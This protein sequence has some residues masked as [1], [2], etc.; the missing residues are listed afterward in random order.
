MRFN[1]IL[2][3]L[4]VFVFKLQGQSF[5]TY[6]TGDTA[7]VV[8]RLAGGVVLMGGGVENDEA[9]RW[10]LR[11]CGGG[12]VL[13]LRAGGGDGYQDYLYKELGISV[14]SV[15]TIVFHS[16]EAAFLPEIESKIKA[17]D[18]L[19]LAG[20]DQSKYLLY[21]KDTPVQTAIQYLISEKNAPVGGTSAGMAVLGQA[22]FAAY[23]NTVGS[24]A[25][26]RNPYAP[27]VSLG[28]DDFIRH[29]DL[30]HII[31]DTHYD[32]RNRKGRHVVFMARLMQDYG[33]QPI[34]IACQTGAAV[35]MDTSGW[36]QVF[37]NFPKSSDFAYF[38]RVNPKHPEGPERCKAGKSLN[39]NCRGQALEVY[40][41]PGTLN[42]SEGI[43]LKDWRR[44]R[45]SNFQKYNWWVQN[46]HLKTRKT[47]N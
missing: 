8:T 1:L 45:G 47:T 17:A 37:G 29:P 42:G 28:Y 36:A 24:R 22:Y 27:E 21:W 3:F 23:L 35:C 6:F 16:R 13:V 9:M 4:C 26:L 40:V 43:Q 34:G 12:D 44:F 33:I 38:I 11:R 10:F 14:N 25:A 19:W 2:C 39:W 18:A 5:E 32:E 46:G 7:D 20:G 30:E 15:E 41:L 31:T